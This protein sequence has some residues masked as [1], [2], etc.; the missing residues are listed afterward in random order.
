MSEVGVFLL[1]TPTAYTAW[2]KFNS[3]SNNVRIYAAL[4]LC[5]TITNYFY[6]ESLFTFSIFFKQNVV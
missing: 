6:D 2:L 1:S 3:N 4:I 5:P